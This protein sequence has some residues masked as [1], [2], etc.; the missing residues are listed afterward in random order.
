MTG[1]L[2]KFVPVKDKMVDIL[3]QMQAPVEEELKRFNVM[4]QET[5][6]HDNP[7][8]NV[9]LSHLSK[10]KGKQMRPLLTLLSA[11][12]HGQVSDNVIHAAVALELLHTASLVHDDVVDESDRRRGQKSINSLLDNRSAVLIGDYILSKALQQAALTQNIRVVEIVSILGQT[13]SDGEL[14]QLN[15]VDSTDFS[16]SSYYEVIRKK[17]ASLFSVCAEVGAILSTGDEGYHFLMKRIGM[18]LGMCFQ[19]KDDL[20]DFDAKQDIGKPAGNDMKE[21]KLTLPALYACQKNKEASEL[22]LLVRKGLADD[23]QISRLVYL[24]REEGGIVYAERAMNEFS[25]MACGLL[26]DIQNKSVASALQLYI[27]FVSKREN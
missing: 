20:L 13:L 12:A 26:D 6:N 3:Q 24:T 22:G 2:R 10:R 15:N 7:L 4:F 1:F 18:L 23:N 25:G 5:L 11:K 14:L 21:G 19:L 9:A 8:L 17:T 16:E 27:D